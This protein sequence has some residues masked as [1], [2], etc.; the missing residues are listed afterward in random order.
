MTPLSGM[1]LNLEQQLF[2]GILSWKGFD[3]SDV[4]LYILRVETDVEY[5][6]PGELLGSSAVKTLKTKLGSLDGVDSFT[7]TMIAQ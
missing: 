6:G 1:S 2:F 7:A 5:S 3:V 4:R